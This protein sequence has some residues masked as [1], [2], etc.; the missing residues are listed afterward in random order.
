MDELERDYSDGAHRFELRMGRMEVLQTGLCLLRLKDGVE[1]GGQDLD[2]LFHIALAAAPDAASLVVIA[3]PHSLSFDAQVALGQTDR[4]GRV[5]LVADRPEVLHMYRCFEQIYNPL[6]PIKYF[7]SV[8]AAADWA[9][10]DT[11]NKEGRRIKP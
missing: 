9:L 4:L 10:F 1:I 7:R 6:F 3:G 8:S 11:S 2:D 5:A